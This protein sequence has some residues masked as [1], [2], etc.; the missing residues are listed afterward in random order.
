MAEHLACLW[1]PTPRVPMLCWSWTSRTQ[2]RYSNG[3]PS[4][5]PGQVS[6]GSVVLPA[7][8]GNL[9]GS[10]LG[11]PMFW[12]LFGRPTW[13]TCLK[14]AVCFYW[15]DWCDRMQSNP[16]FVMQF[17]TGALHMWTL[18][19]QVS[20]QEVKA[21]WIDSCSQMFWICENIIKHHVFDVC[22]MFFLG[23]NYEHNMTSSGPLSRDMSS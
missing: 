20:I 12:S 14:E 21:L 1:V 4:T 6:D 13:P 3:M 8:A 7:R 16:W 9:P 23:K 18:T 10:H 19:S 22:L 15:H 11:V 2:R 5:Q 17:R